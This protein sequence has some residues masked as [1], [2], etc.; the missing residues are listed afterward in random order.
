[1]DRLAC[2]DVPVLPLQLL[3]RSH[4][5]WTSCAVAVVEEDRPHAALLYVNEA[6][7]KVGILPGQKFAAALGL[8][9]DLHAGVV[10]AEEV[11]ASVSEIAERLR[12][13]SPEIEP[14]GDGTPGVFWVDASGLSRLQPSLLAWGRGIAADL[15]DAG[16][17]ATVVVGFRRFGTYAVAKWGRGVKVFDSAGDEDTAV[18]RVPLR[19]LDI[20]PGLRDALHA[21]G[22][23]TVGDF[24]RLPAGGLRQRF[25]DAAYRLHQR[26]AG[27][28]WTP[29]QALPCEEPRVR[30]AELESPDGD[31]VRLLFLVK[32]HL[33]SLLAQLARRSEA[34]TEL[35]LAL[36]LDDHTVY[37]ES[38]RPAAPTLDAVQILGLVRLRLETLTLRSGVVEMELSAKGVRA[39]PGQI[40]LFRCSRRDLDGARRAFARLRAE[41]GEDVVVRAALHDAH[42]PAARFTW[43]RMDGLPERPPAPRAVSPRP[44]VRRLY[45]KPVPLPPRPRQEPDGWL[46]RGLEHGRVE[47]LSGPYVVSG[48]W[49]ARHEVHREYYFARTSRGEL[50]WIYYDKKRRRFFLE[51]RVE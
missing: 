38:L 7:R 11:Q 25:G 20:A 9:G 15:K 39:A 23:H 4:P 18:H 35:T 22:V 5:D 42:L 30:Q 41:L 13:H 27:K 10:S 32:P 3:L 16:F 21:L 31:A 1:V 50:L 37:R 46:L 40:A 49:W 24:L 2:V 51:G 26:A 28:A 43:E 47:R 6:A 33:D 17:T 8:A 34:L 14:D 19:R 12:R 44:L 29:L 36:T 45:K 48:G